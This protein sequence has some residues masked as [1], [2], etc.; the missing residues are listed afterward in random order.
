M[1]PLNV[2]LFSMSARWRQRAARGLDRRGTSTHYGRRSARGKPARAGAG[3]SA[4]VD[5]READDFA[6]AIALHVGG[7]SSAIVRCT[8]STAAAGRCRRKQRPSST[9]TLGDRDRAA[10]PAHRQPLRAFRPGARQLREPGAHGRDGRP[11]RCW[12]SD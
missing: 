11:A 8:T 10:G 6:E 3:H 4:F 1:M 7:G 12:A 2:E 9:G 5:E